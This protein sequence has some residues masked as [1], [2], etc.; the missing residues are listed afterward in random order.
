MLKQL[1]L[2]GGGMLIFEISEENFD[3]V[4]QA[5]IKNLEG[6]KLY[7]RDAFAGAHPD[8][9][10]DLRVVNTKAWQNLFCHNMFFKT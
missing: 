2:F 4:H 6:K 5:M 8:Y 1:I 10:L 9:R 3:R 7:V